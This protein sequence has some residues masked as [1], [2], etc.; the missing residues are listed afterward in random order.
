M[1]LPNAESAVIDISKLRN[2]CL[3]QAHPDGRHKARV[4]FAVLGM[5]ADDAEE[6]RAAII[7]GICR[8]E[9]RD[10]SKTPYGCRYVADIAVSRRDKNAIVR[11]AWI[12]RDGE[13]VPRLVSCYVA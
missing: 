2:Y 10:K 6:L 3:S 13:S 7:E 5:T 8:C 12:I 9:I 4:F 11:T 1:K